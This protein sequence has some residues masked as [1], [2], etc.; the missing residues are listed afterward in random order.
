MADSYTDFL[1][2]VQQQAPSEGPVAVKSGGGEDEYAKFLNGGE[3]PPVETAIAPPDDYTSFLNSVPEKGFVETANSALARGW[4]NI[5]ATVPQLQATYNEYQGGDAEY[6]RQKMAEAEAITK[7]LGE[8]EWNIQNIHSPSDFAMWLT[9]KAGEQG[10][11]FAAM[12]VTG[13]VGGLGA[14]AVAQSLLS[15]AL[16]GQTSARAIMLAGGGIPTGALNI[17]LE[18]A[19]TAEEQFKV[20]GSTQPERSLTAG[21]LKGT[22]ESLVPLSVGRALMTPGRQLGK[23]FIGATGKISAEEGLTEAAQEAVDIYMR[24]LA[25]PDY[26]YF[27]D[28]PTIMP[29]GWGEGMWRLAEAGAAG[30]AVGGI[31]GAGPAKFEQNQETRRAVEKGKALG[32][33]FEGSQASGNQETFAPTS[34]A[35]LNVK[36]PEN[37]FS[38]TKRVPLEQNAV[39]SAGGEREVLKAIGGGAANVNKTEAEL[40][41]EAIV[42]QQAKTYEKKY[43]PGQDHSRDKPEPPIGPITSLRQMVIKPTG[44]EFGLKESLDPNS[45]GDALGINALLAPLKIREDQK[46]KAL[47]ALDASVP[48]YV[49]ISRGDNT[50]LLT[51]TEIELDSALNQPHGTRDTYLKV[52]TGILQPGAITAHLS[53]L[54]PVKSGRIYFL[55]GTQNPIE[56]LVE[57][58]KLQELMGGEVQSGALQSAEIHNQRE[59]V[60]KK[61][62][63]TILS[64][65]LRVVPSRGAGFYYNGVLDFQGLPTA[66]VKTTG[67]SYE[68][69]LYDPVSRQVSHFDGTEADTRPGYVFVSVDRNKLDPSKILPQADGSFILQDG[70][71]GSQLTPGIRPADS[72][73]NFMQDEHRKPGFS[74]TGNVSSVVLD[75]RIAAYPLAKEMHRAATEVMRG[76]DKILAKLGVDGRFIVE[77]TNKDA[78]TIGPHILVSAGIIR[79]QPMFFERFAWTHNIEEMMYEILMHETGHAITWD[80]WKKLP[81]ELQEGVTYA[82]EQ[83]KLAS[84]LGDNSKLL[85]GQPGM[86]DPK[87][88]TGGFSGKAG[89]SEFLAEQFRR[90]G[91]SNSTATTIMEKTFKDGGKKLENYYR[92]L[93]KTLGRDKVMNLTHPHHYFSAFVDWMREYGDNKSAVRQWQKRNTLWEVP[94]DVLDSPTVTGVANVVSRAIESLNPML[95]SGV[96]YQ[97]AQSLAPSIQLSGLQAETAGIFTPKEVTG[98]K[99]FIGLAL[100]VLAKRDDVGGAA[101]E[102]LVHESQHLYE[103]MG[104]YLPE[105]LKLLTAEAKANQEKIFPAAQQAFYRRME[106]ERIKAILAKSGE[107]VPEHIIDAHIDQLIQKELRA[108]YLQSFANNGVAF[109]EQAKTIFARIMALVERIRNYLNGMG[110][111]TKE[112]L[113]RAIFRGEMVHRND[114]AQ[115]DAAHRDWG[116]QIR[117][118]IVMDRIKA[119][120]DAVWEVEGK[121]VRAFYDG[122]GPKK[123]AKGVMYYYFDQEG[124]EVGT[125]EL[126]NKGPKGFDVDMITSEAG[127][128]ADLMLREAE[129]DLGIKIKPSGH[130]TSDG[131]KMAKLGEK[132]G[133]VPKGLLDLYQK[134]PMGDGVYAY[135]SPNYVQG[136]V[137]YWTEVARRTQGGREYKLWEGATLGV[138]QEFAIKQLTKWRAIAAKIPKEVWSD[139]RLEEMFSLKRNFERDEVQGSLIKAGQRASEG[140]L[141]QSLGFPRDTREPFSENFAQKQILSQGENARREGIPFSWAAPT[142]MYSLNVRSVG[143]W[144]TGYGGN[145]LTTKDLSGITQDVDRMSWFAKKFYSLQQI[146]QKNPGNVP[147]Q[148][149][150][151]LAELSGIIQNNWQQRADQTARFWDKGRSFEQ[152]EAINKALFDLTEMKYLKKGEAARL[153]TGWVEFMSGQVFAGT[154]TDAT[155]RAAGIK[156]KEDV[157]L[158]RQIQTDFGDFLTESEKRLG[159][160][161]RKTF[162]NA[163]AQLTSSLTKLAADMAVLRSKPYF[164]MVRFGEY[165]LTRR[166]AK[167][168]PILATYAFSTQRER[169]GALTAMRK[170][171]PQDWITRSRVPIHSVEFMGLPAPLLQQIKEG[172]LDTSQPGLTAEQLSLM[173]QQKDWI[174]QFEMLHMPDKTFRNRW[175]P[176][177][178]VPG[179]SL[180]GLRAYAHYF[181]SGSRYLA[182]LAYMK[183]MRENVQALYARA[184]S[185]HQGDSAKARAIADY[186]GDWLNYYLESGKDSG[187]LRAIA[188]VW[189]LGFSPAAAVMNLTQPFFV[190]FPKMSADFG[191]GKAGAEWLKAQTYV[192]KFKG[193]NPHNYLKGSA[194]Y[195]QAR[196]ELF[197]Q[198]YIDAGQAAELA[199]FAESNNLSK[200]KVGSRLQN[201]FRKFSYW[202]MAGFQVA[203]QYNREVTMRSAWNL[204]TQNPGAKVLDNIKVQRALEISELQSRLGISEDQAA[205]ILYAKEAIQRTQF[206]YNK[207]SDAPFMRGSKK[208]LFIF[209]KYTQNMLFAFGHNGAALQ[210]LLMFAFFYGLQ[211]L[212]GSE[213]A[214]EFLRR[215][216]QWIF[217][218][219]WD[220]H[221]KARELAAGLTKGTIFD[222]TGPDLLMH[223]ISRYGFMGLGM[224]THSWWAPR[225]D[226]SANGSMGKIIPGFAEVMHGFNT[227][228]ATNDIFAEGAQKAAG[229]G[230]GTVFALLHA[231]NDPGSADSKKWAN[232]LMPRALKAVY[233]ANRYGLSQVVGLGSTEPYLAQ[234]LAATD[235]KGAKLVKFDPTDPADKAVILAKALGFSATKV[236]ETWEYIRERNDIESL[237]KMQKTAIMLDMQKA[238]EAGNPEVINDVKKAV[239]KYN[240]MVQANGDPQYSIN[241]QALQQSLKQRLQQKAMTEATETLSKNKG[242]IGLGQR[243]MNLYPGVR[244]ER[245]K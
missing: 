239:D 153:P 164:P 48:R 8:S 242:S 66:E 178:G 21:A 225:F 203:E 37:Y 104:F 224:T 44:Q 162:A 222:D 140:E 46:E 6:T 78:E 106:K 182:R 82:W 155:L 60:G 149:I 144:I 18:T 170:A 202:A 7:P 216:A 107:K 169:D 93:E 29:S 154:E 134:V 213:D 11:N 172:L 139:P 241:G 180:D 219:D 148:M 89:L 141:M 198:G 24:K 208:D 109:S 223:G 136:Q 123:E 63:D 12:A 210:M 115:D 113:L 196:Q 33:S 81:V 45:S 27:K 238:I 163:P 184:N 51:D 16:I 166:S 174:E 74:Q 150:I 137:S 187:K 2:G 243:L 179:H 145:P 197:R 49:N 218:K 91:L 87:Y 14:K 54:P 38:S 118:S 68:V 111:Q 56:L 142:S 193:F 135:F 201:G 67:R 117:H 55:Q 188:A 108:Y 43:P 130:F 58:Q 173:T 199:S 126:T 119:A 171:H 160:N 151:Q 244:A 5:K 159:D 3:T 191:T 181:Q 85:I 90:W 129:R 70:W 31:Y 102:T 19:G 131:F 157:D 25:Q 190:T 206:I 167:D 185:G 220:L 96:Q 194:E 237:Y 229:A 175:M 212:P 41:R 233:E 204:A 147:L 98:N 73:L 20:T 15:R 177:K 214:N 127:G 156:K 42:E 116:N 79:I 122:D 30:M 128:M 165:T 245:V 195:L 217:G 240:D 158:I 120:G 234:P 26:S 143:D 22:L 114:R 186:A 125:L 80:Y 97:L 61:L 152:R 83:A 146:A 35:Q 57:Y 94:Q 209:F 59:A 192:G 124:N 221:A 100:S 227:G 138:T 168:G 88:A 75:P 112:D 121:I 23:T 84:A 53:D 133:R 99:D 76:M 52:D 232:V 189:Y 101:R 71:D 39:Y 235:S 4:G 230:Y 105:E 28:G 69:A 36:L 211:G 132:F 64:K 10:A 65:G 34:M 92:E 95:V 215:A 77:I 226:A 110:Y 47:D 176:A 205:A 207:T 228:K 40:R 236:N 86:Y 200:L 1:N 183:E 50:R 231:L 17:G 161:L 62:Y 9:E 103:Q 32:F 13:G 72:D